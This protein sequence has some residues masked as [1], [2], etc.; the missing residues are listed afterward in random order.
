MTDDVKVDVRRSGRRFDAEAVLDLAAD[1]QTVWDTITDYGALPSFMP[2][3]RA[4]RVIERQPLAKGRA[5]GGRAARRVPFPVVRA[6]DD[7]AAEH[8]AP[9]AARGRGEGRE[10]R[11][12]PVQAPRDRC[13]RGSLRADAAGG[14]PR[15]AA[16]AAAL[17]RADRTAPA[18]AARDRQRGGPAEPR[19]PARSGGPGGRPTQRPTAPA[20]LAVG[21]RLP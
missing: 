4:C 20:R 5:S 11:P 2:G 12:R 10:L 7:G 15:R 13:V 3:I 9:A 16:D 8:R 18:A 17:H 1:A 14:A 6:G 21:H 19:G